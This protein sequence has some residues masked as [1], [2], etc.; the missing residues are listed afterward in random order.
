[1]NRRRRRRRKSISSKRVGIPL[2]PDAIHGALFQ[3]QYNCEMADRIACSCVTCPKCGTWVVVKQQ[4]ELGVRREKFRAS[5]PLPECGKEF[6]FESGE[7]R[8]FELPLTIFERRY[9]YRSEL[10]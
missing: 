6:E 7:T 9:F 5:C 8:L 1:M 2:D 3:A 10:A 4:S